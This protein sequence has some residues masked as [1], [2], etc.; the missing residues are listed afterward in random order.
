[1]RV[2]LKK[3]LAVKEHVGGLRKKHS[4][5]CEP[6]ALQSAGKWIKGARLSLLEMTWPS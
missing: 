4:R 6:T 2:L 3:I 5:G 1:M